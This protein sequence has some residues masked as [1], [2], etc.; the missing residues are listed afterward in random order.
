MTETAAQPAQTRPP[1]IGSDAPFWIA[2]SIIG[3]LYV[4]LIAALVLV[5][6]IHTTP[7]ALAAVLGDPAIRYSIRLSLISCSIAAILSLWVA[8]PLGY[9]MSRWHAPRRRP[10]QPRSATCNW[11][12]KGLIDAILETLQ[13]QRTAYA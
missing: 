13:S 4:L 5:D 10:G 3:A 12:A 6:L 11:L 8:V 7:A 2:L 1:R 9:L